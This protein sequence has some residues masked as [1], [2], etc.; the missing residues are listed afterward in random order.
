[1]ATTNAKV[2]KTAEELAEEQRRKL[3]A[4]GEEYVEV[5]LFKDGGKY[6]DDVFVSI[7]GESCLIKRGVPV[8]I[9]KK[10][11]NLINE[12]MMAEAKVTEKL[13][14]LQAEGKKV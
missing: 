3:I 13:E 6:K 9:K 4:E 11:A 2:E 8:K 10:F 5:M 12:S 7:N 1:M 14:R